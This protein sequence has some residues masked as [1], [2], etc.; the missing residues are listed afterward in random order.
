MCIYVWDICLSDWLFYRGW[1]IGIS[2]CGTY[3]E[4]R[5]ISDVATPDLT[6]DWEEI[7]RQ[8]DGWV[9]NPQMTVTCNQRE[10]NILLT[11]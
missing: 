1:V 11:F 7:P 4:A 9:D 6:T 2:V 3:I 5:S 10:L 8:V